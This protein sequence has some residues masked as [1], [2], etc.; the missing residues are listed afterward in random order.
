MTKGKRLINA[1]PELLAACKMAKKYL[2]PVLDEP[3]RTVFWTLVDA[4][5]KA[6]GS[7]D[8]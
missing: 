2:E 7:E 5:M 4:I 6:E 3:G 8:I 1:A